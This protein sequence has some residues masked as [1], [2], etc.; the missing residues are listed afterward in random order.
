MLTVTRHVVQQVCGILERTYGRPR[1]GNPDDP[2]DDLIYII[3]SNRTSIEVAQ[4]VLARLKERF[5]TWDEVLVGTPR[6]LESIV[7]PAGL[8]NKRS[9]HIRSALLRIR[10]DFYHCDLSELRNWDED[11]I[12]AYLTSLPGVSEKVAK[13]VMLFTLGIDVLP[14]DSHVHRITRRLGWTFRKRADQCHHE[15][16]AIVLPKYR[17]VLHV[18]CIMHGRLVCRSHDPL[19]K[20]CIIKRYCA[21]YAK[22]KTANE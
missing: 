13:C 19:C 12:A 6:S 11:R 17:Y 22:V 9:Q 21:Y 4:Q 2:L 10:H 5:R 7:R 18:G 20:Q 15:L 3:V 16:E 1:L 14:V 8:Y